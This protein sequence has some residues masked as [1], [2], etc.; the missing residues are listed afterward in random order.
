MIDC[1]GN[2]GLSVIRSKQLYP[3][4][5]IVVFEPD[6]E[7]VPV[8]KRNLERND[9]GDVEVIDAA[10]W[11]DNG[12]SQ[13]YCEG[14]DGSHLSSEAGQVSKPTIVRTIDLNWSF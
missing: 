3:D 12:T 13:W 5:R 9:A 2:I 14:I 4:S 11:I 6:P 7:F 8:L 1:G 10:V